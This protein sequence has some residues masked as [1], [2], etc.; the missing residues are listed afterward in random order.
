LFYFNL[1]LFRETYVTVQ[2]FTQEYLN[3]AYF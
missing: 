2:L 1:C 3:S